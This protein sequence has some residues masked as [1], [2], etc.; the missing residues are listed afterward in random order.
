MTQIIDEIREVEE[1]SEQLIQ[2][3]RGKVRQIIEEAKAKSKE[4]L[5]EAEK[6]A[7]EETASL[8]EKAIEEAREE[9]QLIDKDTV[10]KRENL[11]EVASKNFPE[12]VSFIVRRILG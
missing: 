11:K 9:A 1:E 3:A 4:L 2:E 7:R 5:A 6:E 10:K 12:A 8:R